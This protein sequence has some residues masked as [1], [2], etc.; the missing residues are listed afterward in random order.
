MPGPNA[1]IVVR[2][3]AGAAAVAAALRE[4]V[5]PIDPDAP[6]LGVMPF[7][8]MIAQELQLLLVFGSM[9]GL[10]A[11]AALGIAGIG[12]YAVTAYAV[13]QRTREMGVR[14]ALG[15]RARH[16]WWVVTRRAA[17]QL[18]VGIALGLAGALGAGELLQGLLT[19]VGSRDP[20]TLIGVPVVMIAVS[21][22]A[23]VVPAR[24][25]MRLDPVAALR[26]E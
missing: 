16:V 9:F 22:V 3:S 20:L 25:A 19:G 18:G 11:S 17:M 13:A 8:E 2:S 14:I 23:C 21:L 12:L 15:A 26:A 7:D 4:V 5:R 1:A 24:R 10:F 6:V